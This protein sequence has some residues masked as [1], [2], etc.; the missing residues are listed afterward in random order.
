MNPRIIKYLQHILTM[1]IIGH[2]LRVNVNS[3]SQTESPAV[4]ME[5]LLMLQTQRIRFK[6]QAKTGQFRAA[7]NH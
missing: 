5:R 1:Y 3:R 6:S 7:H 4:V 2:D